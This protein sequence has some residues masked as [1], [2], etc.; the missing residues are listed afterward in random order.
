[1]VVTSRPATCTTGVKQETTRGPPTCTVHAPQW[2]WSQPFFAPVRSNRSRSTSRRDSRGPTRISTARVLTRK[3]TSIES[4]AS[5]QKA[6]ELTGRGQLLDQ[7]PMLRRSGR[8]VLQGDDRRPGGA[9]TQVASRAEC[10]T[11][12]ILADGTEGGLGRSL[13][14]AM[15][16]AASAGELFGWSSAGRPGTGPAGRAGAAGRSARLPPTMASAARSVRA[17]ERGADACFAPFQAVRS[18][19]L[20]CCA[21]DLRDDGFITCLKPLG[22]FSVLGGRVKRVRRPGVP[23]SLRA[24]L[25]RMAQPSRLVRLAG[26]AWG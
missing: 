5:P 13:G 21:G 1:M 18:A 10:G 23:D 25:L 3:E 11:G 16:Q 12:G 24:C 6:W 26:L 7:R 22:R 9:V 2:P 17:N 8:P 20:A 14:L 4:M 19:C 15:R